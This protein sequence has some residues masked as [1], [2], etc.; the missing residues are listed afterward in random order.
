MPVIESTEKRVDVDGITRDVLTMGL[1]MVT[2]RYDTGFHRHRKAQCVMAVSG[3]LTCE[4]EG[5]IWIVPPQDAVWIPPGIEHRITLAGSVE[6]YNAFIEP[7]VA[8]GLPSACCT[9]AATP[10]L[11]ELLVRTAQY[12]TDVPEGGME[13]RVASLLL[14]EIAIAEVG[15]MHLPMPKD[16]RLRAVF[17][18]IVECPADRGT[19]VAWAMRHAMSERT[20]ARLV[21]AETGM[22]FGRWRQQLG[23]ILAIQRMAEGA[24]V[25]QVAGDLGYESVG[26]FVTMFRKALGTS[27]GRYMSGRS[28]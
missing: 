14:E 20:F 24:S 1:K 26:S 25:Q 22:S 6:G 13:S 2:R 17:R 28:S 21:V 10:L 23:V 27:P 7:A 8:R 11:R 18:S 12:P 5:G 3:V 16:E 19:L 9:I 4:A 15:G